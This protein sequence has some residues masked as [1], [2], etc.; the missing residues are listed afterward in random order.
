MDEDRVIPLKEV[1]ATKSQ[2][3]SRRATIDE[4]EAILKAD[5]D[6]DIQI[7][8]NGKVVTRKGKKTAKVLTFRENLGGEYAMFPQPNT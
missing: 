3:K 7:L 8:P 1:R 6:V 5:E 4:L 2:P